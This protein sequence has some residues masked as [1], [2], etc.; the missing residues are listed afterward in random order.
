[1]ADAPAITFYGGNADATVNMID[2]FD[3]TVESNDATFVVF[4]RGL[5]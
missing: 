4:Y 1:M 3:K 2:L 5:W